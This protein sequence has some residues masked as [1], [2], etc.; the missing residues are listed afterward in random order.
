MHDYSTKMD[1][2]EETDLLFLSLYTSGFLVVLNPQNRDVNACFWYFINKRI[3]TNTNG[4]DHAIKCWGTGAWREQASGWD[5]AFLCLFM[6]FLWIL[7]RK[8]DNAELL[9]AVALSPYFFPVLVTFLWKKKC[10]QHILKA[11]HVSSLFSPL[12]LV[13]IDLIMYS[14]SILIT[15]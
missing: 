2:K 7:H 10:H 8:T 6:S 13:I 15:T 9:D 3:S 11:F 14:K 5:E 12:L 4:H 1:L